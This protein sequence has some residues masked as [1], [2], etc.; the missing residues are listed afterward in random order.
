M[1]FRDFRGRGFIRD[2]KLSGDEKKKLL[3]T[4]RLLYNRAL[5]ICLNNYIT[6]RPTGFIYF[7]FFRRTRLFILKAPWWNLRAV[8]GD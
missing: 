6:R 4:A 7:F 8:D 2:G 5:V 3:E 1:Y